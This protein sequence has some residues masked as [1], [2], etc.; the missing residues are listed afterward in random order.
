V[1]GEKASRGRCPHAPPHTLS[2]QTSLTCVGMEP[3]RAGSGPPNNPTIARS[4]GEPKHLASSPE[5]RAS[6]PPSDLPAPLW[7]VYRLGL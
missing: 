3:S 7:C 6:L 2:L 5:E 4:S 1:K